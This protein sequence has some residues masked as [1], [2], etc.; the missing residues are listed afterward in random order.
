MSSVSSA[1]L[2]CVFGTCHTQTGWSFARAYLIDPHAPKL[3][4]MEIRESLATAGKDNVGIVPHDVFPC[5]CEGRFPERFGKML[6]FM[7][8]YSEEL[9]ELSG[10]IE[11]L[12]E[13][14]AELL[15]DR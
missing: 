14:A 15:A 12:P 10:D 5:Y 6:D 1:Q 8:V 11:W 3:S 2:I 7:H 4:E 13:E 9:D